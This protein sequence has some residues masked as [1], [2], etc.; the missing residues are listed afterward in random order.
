M[1][2]LPG[3][4]GD[5]WLNF[6]RKVESSGEAFEG[7]GQAEPQ[8]Y[9]LTFGQRSEQD[10]SGLLSNTYSMPGR[11]EDSEMNWG[12]TGLYL[13]PIVGGAMDFY[14]WIFEE[15]ETWAGL[16]RNIMDNKAISGL[17][18]VGNFLDFMPFFG[19]KGAIVAQRALGHSFGKGFKELSRYVF[20]GGLKY[21][22]PDQREVRKLLRNKAFQA[23]TRD[24]LIAAG[25]SDLPLLADAPHL[26]IEGFFNEKKLTDELARL[27]E[28]GQEGPVWMEFKEGG[29]FARFATKRGDYATAQIVNGEAGGFVAQ[30]R[31]G[32]EPL[33]FGAWDTI[34]DAKNAMAMVPFS[35]T[36][37]NHMILMTTR[38]ARGLP[39]V[40]VSKNKK[41]LLEKMFAEAA[42]TDYVNILKPKVRS[43]P[44][45][46]FLELEQ[47]QGMIDAASAGDTPLAFRDR[48]IIEIAMLGMRPSELVNL[49]WGDIRFKENL[50]EGV[51]TIKQTKTKRTKEIRFGSHAYDALKDYEKYSRKKLFGPKHVAK[52]YEEGIPDA[53]SPLFI[54]LKGQRMQVSRGKAIHGTKAGLTGVLNKYFKAAVG[55]TG[56][57]ITP[58]VM[59]E[60][61]A[62]H[63]YS[64]GTDYDDIVA[65]LGHVD[66][67]TL[68][69]SY[70]GPYREWTL[71][72][73][74]NGVP[75]TKAMEARIAEEEADAIVHMLRGGFY[76]TPSDFVALGDPGEYANYTRED[77]RRMHK[78]RKKK[79]GKLAYM[80]V[81]EWKTILG[82]FE[83]D[84]YGSL[85]N[86]IFQIIYSTAIRTSELVNIRKGDLDLKNSRIFIRG[87]KAV[88]RPLRGERASKGRWVKL[89]KDAKEAL[90]EY[91][92]FLQMGTGNKQGPGVLGKGAEG[93][94]SY[95]AK[96][97]WGLKLADMADDEHIFKATKRGNP[98]A[99]R[100][101]HGGVH[102][103]G[104][105]TDESV[106][107]MMIKVTKPLD[108]EGVY[109]TTPTRVRTSRAVHLRDMNYSWNEIKKLFGHTL[110]ETVEDYY[111]AWTKEQRAK[112]LKAQTVGRALAQQEW[113][114]SL[115]EIIQE[116]GK[117]LW[118]Y[119]DSHIDFDG[120]EHVGILKR[121][122]F[123]ERREILSLLVANKA[124][125]RRAAAGTAKMRQ[126]DI[127]GRAGV[128]KLKVTFD[129]PQLS[130]LGK[131]TLEK[132]KY[133]ANKLEAE[134][135]KGAPADDPFVQSQMSPQKMFTS[136]TDPE[137]LIG[138]KAAA[139]FAQA[140]STDIPQ[141]AAF[142]R[143]SMNDGR[144]RI[145]TFFDAMGDP[146][147]P[148][149]DLLQYSAGAW[150]VGKGVM[151][152]VMFEGKPMLKTVLN[153]Q[154]YEYGRYKDN[155]FNANYRL[156]AIDDELQILTEQLRV[157]QAYA[158]K[159]AAVQGH[160]AG[161]VLPS[162]LLPDPPA[163][164]QGVEA[165]KETLEKL[166]KAREVKVEEIATIERLGP[167]GDG[168]LRG[169]ARRVSPEELEEARRLD[170]E[171]YE[172]YG[173]PKVTR[174]YQNERARL[175]I[176]IPGPR[177]DG[178]KGNNQWHPRGPKPEGG[179]KIS[180]P[181]T[182][183]KK[184]RPED[185]E[186]D[187]IYESEAMQIVATSSGAELRPVLVIKVLRQTGRGKGKHFE[188]L[189]R[190]VDRDGKELAVLDHFSGET[191]G[192]VTPG[193]MEKQRKGAGAAMDSS[194]AP[195]NFGRSVHIV[196]GGGGR[197]PTV[198][199]AQGAM[200]G[201]TARFAKELMEAQDEAV[202][203]GVRKGLGRDRY[204]D[205]FGYV[206]DDP[207]LPASL[208]EFSLPR[209]Q[210]KYGIK[211]FGPESSYS[212][213]VRAFEG[214]WEGVV[215]RFPRL[216]RNKILKDLAGMEETV[217]ELMHQGLL[218][219][220]EK[221]PVPTLSKALRE[222]AQDLP[223]SQGVYLLKN[224]KG[225]VVYVGKANSIRGRVQSH[226]SNVQRLG[227]KQKDMVNE[228]KDIDFVVTDT[229]AEAF[230]LENSLIKRHNPKF[231]VALKGEGPVLKVKKYR[232]DVEE[233]PS[234]E[235]IRASNLLLR[236]AIENSNAS[237]A[238]K[239]SLLRKLDMDEKAVENARKAGRSHITRSHFVPE[240]GYAADAVTSG[241]GGDAYY[242]KYR[243][244][245]ILFLRE[246]IEYVKQ[247]LRSTD[248]YSEWKGTFGEGYQRKYWDDM[249][250]WDMFRAEKGARDPRE[251]IAPGKRKPGKY[252]YQNRR[253][254]KWHTDWNALAADFGPRPWGLT[255]KGVYN[256][257]DA[258]AGW[259]YPRPWAR[260]AAHQPAP[261]GKEG[262]EVAGAGYLPH[263]KVR[264]TEAAKQLIEGLDP[265]QTPGMFK[266]KPDPA[267]IAAWHKHVKQRP[268]E[269]YIRA[270]VQGR[271]ADIRGEN[272]GREVAPRG[273][274][275]REAVF[276]EYGR[277]VQREQLAPIGA[278]E[279][280]MIIS[281]T[282]IEMYESARRLNR[283]IAYEVKG[284]IPG[285]EDMVVQDD[286][287]TK[288]VD[289]KFAWMITRVMD[290]P[291]ISRFIP[292]RSWFRFAKRFG[293][294]GIKEEYLI[295]G[296]WESF[297][298][299]QTA[300]MTAIHNQPA[301]EL[302]ETL[303][304]KAEQ[305]IDPDMVKIAEE[306][307]EQLQRKGHTGLALDAKTLKL[308]AK[309]VKNR[310][311]KKAGYLHKLGQLKAVLGGVGHDPLIR[312][313]QLFGG[314]IDAMPV[315][316]KIAKGGGKLATS[317]RALTP[318]DTAIGRA[319]GNVKDAGRIEFTMEDKMWLKISTATSR[320]LY[321]GL[322]YGRI[323]TAMAQ[324]TQFI[325]D[326]ADMGGINT[327]RGVAILAKRS[328]TKRGGEAALQALV[329]KESFVGMGIGAAAGGLF[330]G[331]VAIAVGAAI[332]PVAR[333][334]KAA[335]VTSL[336][337]T[338]QAQ[339]N[340]AL[341]VGINP[342][343]KLLRGEEF[344]A[345]SNRLWHYLD[346]SGFSFL[347]T[348]ETILRGATFMTSL[349][350]AVRRGYQ[351]RGAIEKAIEGVVRTQFVY[352]Q[353][354]RNPYWRHSVIGSLGAPL[355][356]FPMKQGAFLRR[357]ITEDATD[358]APPIVAMTRYLF[359]NGLVA[360]AL[361]Q[362][363]QWATGEEM[364]LRELQG[365][366][367]V[368][369]VEG[370]L[371]PTGGVKGPE[372]FESVMQF[373]PGRTPGYQ[374]VQALGKWM[375]GNVE[376]AQ[377]MDTFVKN[378]VPFGLVVSDL[379]RFGERFESGQ[380]RRQEGPWTQLT[381]GSSVG[382]VVRQTTKVRE[383]GRLFGF[384]APQEA[385]EMDQ[386]RRAARLAET[387]ANSSIIQE[388][389][390][391]VR[392]PKLSPSVKARQ[393]K[394]LMGTPEGLRKLAMGGIRAKEVDNYSYPRLKR[395][396][397][398]LNVPFRNL[399]EAAI[400]GDR[401][402]KQKAVEIGMPASHFEYWMGVVRRLR[403]EERGI[404]GGE[405]L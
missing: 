4:G 24:V 56:E 268:G 104:A 240:R 391:I 155:L 146:D 27:K 329:S 394:E 297:S 404:I 174:G 300:A 374:V 164:M 169:M 196:G 214:L 116:H 64:Q 381:R 368:S 151:R 334:V 94:K 223:T 138:M 148:F 105:L 184:M 95:L 122:P 193:L 266:P 338:A 358:G 361:R 67:Q 46:R 61:F 75:T 175:R 1:S 309:M 362:G 378:F 288:L 299:Y 348:A 310:Y 82:S 287:M 354:A 295:H 192:E 134:H 84:P 157:E 101:G 189:W 18:F 316:R 129:R 246:Q 121:Y 269:K 98:T 160:G 71:D 7:L 143:R 204:L 178:L 347:D 398:G 187:H 48:A 120:V 247:T 144:S 242:S 260:G 229:S 93:A 257:S 342:G 161:P 65:L 296:F 208:R 136:G 328:A 364:V 57:R 317:L 111:S 25:G 73:L 322:L 103:W 43:V 259:V 108:S 80:D 62:V 320:M 127:P 66:E 294:G 12:R 280:R 307:R 265:R 135:Y 304:K 346:E 114:E 31:I 349:D 271:E 371:G 74:R 341:R 119:V 301:F 50:K 180:R 32:E 165:L 139:G 210:D 244:S 13:L 177:T 306:A 227:Q 14:S 130:E 401:F 128:K 36:A 45:P 86:A 286:Y 132:W 78:I 258:Q 228:V 8:D 337:P 6:G 3:Q 167:Q 230:V 203:L 340:L 353:I 190:P 369:M 366:I 239:K 370:F 186:P 96:E 41:L 219:L 63:L 199:H 350:I 87:P 325:N 224:A 33:H 68:K 126:L 319:V 375:R 35:E 125:E 344:I 314:I 215:P 42:E 110:E 212:E 141:I 102:N 255:A 357:L 54:D 85:N 90:D 91:L 213:R 248:E 153:K 302:L 170:E 335:A 97:G 377:L 281:D 289:Q 235:V 158:K 241:G 182:K 379:A 52:Y 292:H 194:R 226:V 351:G 231:N 278:N 22:T 249:P 152:N 352:D 238:M 10:Y 201:T 252:E 9:W 117:G 47:L 53:G 232:V 298:E 21:Q 315:V 234:M 285:Y 393:I 118:D 99:R 115:Q 16:Y 392:D 383:Y 17:R 273:D 81:D 243:H 356:S 38:A 206:A 263:D 264:H 290:S 40:A 112:G 92:R 23:Q 323:P 321:R 274:V 363:S 162:D 19:L 284:S 44:V 343:A 283:Q 88:P 365:R 345:S 275:V 279:A 149:Q 355:S 176:I 172:E 388:Y 20:F 49:D 77:I 133:K 237:A 332:T 405:Y 376:D 29:V 277:L 250:D 142:I 397:L 59:R 303:I 202:R 313:A 216:N 195:E 79:S 211:A 367:D 245:S 359:F 159:V 218:D 163:D 76:R 156:K 72:E 51:L 113:D 39:N 386:E 131:E 236:E 183:G 70:L 221:G 28:L 83:K 293:M 403:R 58:K 308:Q 191:L 272:F 312:D 185:V 179:W 373:N 109:L 124:L 5:Y 69:R 140:L 372:G 209:L 382:G 188:Q 318:E 147:G 387:Y 327:I 330:L 60:T 37:L 402:A 198:Y 399:I 207:A 311:R 253:T 217:R 339:R 384:V 400:A 30:L 150:R 262:L 15:E 55:P 220:S 333:A 181:G 291:Q 267:A 360:Q 251:I 107:K 324:F 205:V 270:P 154:I 261:P 331:P 145:H 233:L 282:A 168:S 11:A 276:D 171:F 389:E 100:R 305:G 385:L 395:T 254:R 225:E 26:K 137:E 380:I 173:V 390:R 34:A 2:P 197:F 166:N 396:Y 326:A 106:R 89:D 222:M 256:L 123:R 200:R 336:G